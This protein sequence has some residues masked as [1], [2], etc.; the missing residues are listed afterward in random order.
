[1]KRNEE[2]I[3]CRDLHDIQSNLEDEF[4]DPKTSKIFQKPQSHVLFEKKN[5]VDNVECW[6][7]V[8]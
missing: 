3:E 1:M 6:K 2:Y 5:G 8:K 7:E 4:F